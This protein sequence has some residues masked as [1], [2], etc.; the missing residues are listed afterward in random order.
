[1]ALQS[2]AAVMYV[3]QQHGHSV[4]VMLASYAKWLPNADAGRNRD[5][6]NRAIAADVTV[7]K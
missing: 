5:A 1:M 7:Q 3:A 6:V 4:Q 2:G